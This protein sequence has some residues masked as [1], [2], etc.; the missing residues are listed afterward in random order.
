MMDNPDQY[1]R[2]TFA[3]GNFFDAEAAFRRVC[4]VVATA[5]GYAGGSVPDPTYEQVSG[6]DSG[7]AEAVQIIFDPALVSYDDLL[8]LFWEIHDP[9]R[10]GQQGDYDGPQY[11]SIIFYHDDTQKAAAVA[12]RGR[13]HVPGKV[14]QKPVVTD[15]LP[16]PRFWL[17]EECHQQFYEKC[18]RSHCISRQVD[19]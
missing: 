12:S 11:R 7:H 14:E 4:G 15:I 6:G 8:A 18:L 5:T 13:V 1:Q 10:Q 3:A 16:V 2:A 9:T 19:E 17:A